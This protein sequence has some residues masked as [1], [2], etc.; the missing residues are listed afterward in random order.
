MTADRTAGGRAASGVIDAHAHLLNTAELRYRWIEPR[1]PALT[2]LLSNYYDIA[3]DFTPADYTRAVA[4]TGITAVVACE[5]GAADPIAEAQW[6]QR[7]H[8][9]TGTPAAFIAAVDLSS[10]NVRDDLARYADLPVV[11]AVRQ[12]LYWANNPLTRLGARPDFLTDPVWLRGFERVAATGL[13]WDLLLYDE[14]L[15]QA[16]QLLKSFPEVTI[17][18]EAAG[19]PLD[20]GADGFWRWRDRLAAI[21][22]YPNVFLKLQGLALIFGVNG[23]AIGPWL[24]AAVDI[25]GADRCLFATHL[26]VDGL[27]WTCEQLLNVTRASLRG[28]DPTAERDYLAGTAERVYVPDR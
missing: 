17:V 23:A 5:F 10:P 7:C 15:P 26:P 13:V 4:G 2:H 6:V 12:P 28:L 19:W 20:R 18:L 11:R 24:R 14:Q 9:A 27:L 1:N 3:R 16:V 22:R 21:S 8:D 25:F